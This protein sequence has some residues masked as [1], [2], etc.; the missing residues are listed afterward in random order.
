[1]MIGNTFKVALKLPAGLFE[2]MP[3]VYNIPTIPR[4]LVYERG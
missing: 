3:A 1:M 2:F 4:M